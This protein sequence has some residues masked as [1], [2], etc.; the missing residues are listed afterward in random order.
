M[1]DERESFGPVGFCIYCGARG[2][3]DNPISDEHIIPEGMGG[4]L[5]LEMASCQKCAGVI[6]AAEGFCQRNMFPGLRALYDLYGKQ[7]KK[8]RPLAFPLTIKTK[9]KLLWSDPR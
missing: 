8:T 5:V 1:T 4:N 6:S 2:A 7:R 9:R 3:E